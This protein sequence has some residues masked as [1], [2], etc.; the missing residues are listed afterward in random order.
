MPFGHPFESYWTVL[1]CSIAFQFGLP[2]IY[3]VN[4]FDDYMSTFNE[5]LAELFSHHTLS[6]GTP[7]FITG[8]G[9]NRQGGSTSSV[10]QEAMVPLISKKDC[11]R[12]YRPDLITSNMLCAGFQGGGIDACKG[13]SGGKIVCTLARL[14]CHSGSTKKSPK[15]LRAER[16]KQTI[17][18]KVCSF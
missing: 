1:S 14:S 16:P 11:K 4:F 17:S 15:H 2:K 8:W 13:D 9:R 5:G 12:N 6:L 7:C 3:C 18:L 10:L